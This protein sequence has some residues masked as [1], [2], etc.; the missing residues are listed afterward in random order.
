MKSHKPSQAVTVPCTLEFRP[1]RMKWFV[2]ER[3]NSRWPFGAECHEYLRA[4]ALE[5]Q[6][7]RLRDAWQMQREFFAM[8]EDCADLI[9]FLNKWGYWGDEEELPLS[10]AGRTVQSPTSIWTE[11]RVYGE[12]LSRGAEA[13]LNTYGSLLALESRKKFPFFSSVHRDCRSALR[14]TITFDILAKVEFRVCTREDCETIFSL[15][16]DGNKRPRSDKRY[17][18][19]ECSH[20]ALVRRGREAAKASGKS[21]AKVA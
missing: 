1:P 7:E 8:R 19:P 2:Y 17:C 16:S 4:E 6:E 3:P 12:I 15:K 5:D 20:L 9:R 18:S 21:S 13:W 14:A 10:M 11:R